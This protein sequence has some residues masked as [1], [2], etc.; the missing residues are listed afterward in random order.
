MRNENGDEG[1]GKLKIMIRNTFLATDEACVAIY[2]NLPKAIRV[3]SRGDLN[4]CVHSI[5]LRHKYELIQC[6]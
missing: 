1:N 6:P 5:P 4:F 3:L 2:S